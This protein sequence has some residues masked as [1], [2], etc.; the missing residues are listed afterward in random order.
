MNLKLSNPQPFP[1]TIIPHYSCYY[2]M[3]FYCYYHVND[4]VKQQKVIYA[5]TCTIR[6]KHDTATAVNLS[7]G[8]FAQSA[9]PVFASQ[10]A[11][12][13]FGTLIGFLFTIKYACHKTSRYCTTVRSNVQQITFMLCVLMLTCQNGKDELQN[14]VP[15]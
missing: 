1:K 5:C 4:H 11:F 8:N 7:P 15:L 12:Y 9:M 10:C 3:T 14:S 13:I 2:T 6:E